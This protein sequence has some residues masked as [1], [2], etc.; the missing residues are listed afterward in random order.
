MSEIIKR[1]YA[2]PNICKYCDEVIRILDGQSAAEVRRKKFCDRA[3]RNRYNNPLRR[4]KTDVCKTCNKEFE[5]YKTDGGVWSISKNCK[6]CQSLGYGNSIAFMMKTKEEVYRTYKTKFSARNA[7]S[8]NAQVVYKNSNRPYTCVICGYAKHVD[9]AH[10]KSVADFDNSV[11]MS[12][13][14]NISNLVALCPNHHW[15][16]DNNQLDEKDL[17]KIVD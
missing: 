11:P 5:R 16:F 6:F 1:Y 4:K 8:G 17:R 3:C 10:I 7:I 9:I 15:E 2:N 14:N 12:E 13:I